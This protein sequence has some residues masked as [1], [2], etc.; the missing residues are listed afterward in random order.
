MSRIPAASTL[1]DP[2]K[3]SP[4]N[5]CLRTALNARYVEFLMPF[6][7]LFRQHSKIQGAVQL[8]DMG[9]AVAAAG[10]RR[11]TPR[12]FEGLRRGDS[13]GCAVG[14]KMVNL[15]DYLMMRIKD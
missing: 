2:H 13:K 4:S 14:F 5:Q 7:S 3:I 8:P 1:R 15:A 6:R 9:P 10:I 11:A 12:G